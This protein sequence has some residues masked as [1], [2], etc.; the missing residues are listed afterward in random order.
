MD[1]MWKTPESLKFQGF[2]AGRRLVLKWQKD[3]NFLLA[4]DFYQN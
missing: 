1:K 3:F 2:N 4:I